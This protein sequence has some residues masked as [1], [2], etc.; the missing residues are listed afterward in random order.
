MIKNKI[1]LT[2]DKDSF[3]HF[4]LFNRFPEIVASIMNDN[5]LDQHVIAKLNNLINSFPNGEIHP[6]N[7]DGDDVDSINTVILNQKLTW[8]NAPF[9]FV[10]NYLYQYFAEIMDY[11]KNKFDYF[12][13]K[14][15]K[16]TIESLSEMKKMFHD[17]NKLLLMNLEEGLGKVLLLNLWGNKADLSQSEMN[18]HKN[19]SSKLLINHSDKLNESIF[20]KKRIDIILDNAGVELFSDL[21]L[22][23]WII[24][25]TPIEKIFLHCKTIPYF[26]SD[27]L[28]SDLDWLLDFLQKDSMLE[29]LSN[30]LRSQIKKGKILLKSHP[31]WCTSGLYKDMP[32]DLVSE[33][34]NSDLL[35]F[36]GDLNYRKLVGDFRWKPTIKTND[37]IN[38]ISVPVLIIRILKS[39]VIVGLQEQ[40]IPNA[41]NNEWM[42][43]GE[44]GIIEFV[45][46][47]M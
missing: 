1:I 45:T 19:S 20:L 38:Y 7:P 34:N 28:E 16:Q 21:L 35:I 43:N 46:S 12:G 37:L 33:L 39:E 42:Y 8:D 9:L 18:Y 13:A 27:T 44:Y 17:F 41:E 47:G 3:A 24:E 36:K 6:L 26:V 22:V 5:Q 32:R 40:D 14:K 2:S 25:N 29:G 30:Y 23:Y 15:R 11:K 4:T 10:E 31:F